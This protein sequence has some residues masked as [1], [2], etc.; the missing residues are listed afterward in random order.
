M[1][2][3]NRPEF[4]EFPPVRGAAHGGTPHPNLIFCCEWDFVTNFQ[5]V[6]TSSVPRLTKGCLP[7]E[8]KVRRIDFGFS[9]W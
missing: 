8:M 4:I 5:K 1:G 2:K 6:Q 9:A 7:R 3:H